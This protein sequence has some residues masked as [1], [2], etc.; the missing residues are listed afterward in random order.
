M[1]ISHCGMVHFSLL[2][3]WLRLNFFV[4]LRPNSVSLENSFAFQ[5]ISNVIFPLKA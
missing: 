5:N 2:I 4:E 3:L 1:H